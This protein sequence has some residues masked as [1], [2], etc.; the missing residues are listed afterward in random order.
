MAVDDIGN[1][2]IVVFIFK[3]NIPSGALI[4]FVKNIS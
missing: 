3:K 1:K 2:I 4:G